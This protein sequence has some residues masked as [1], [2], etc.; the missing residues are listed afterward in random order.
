MYFVCTVIMPYKQN[1]DLF[2]SVSKMSPSH[3]ELY[4]KMHFQY[5][6]LQKTIHLQNSS[7]VI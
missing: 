7:S 6:Y 2:V 4:T 3:Y 1:K 5:V